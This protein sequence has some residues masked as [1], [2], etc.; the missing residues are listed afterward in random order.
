VAPGRPPFVRSAQY[1]AAIIHAALAA[2]GHSPDLVQIVTGEKEIL[3][4]RRKRGILST[5]IPTHIYTL[6]HDPP[7]SSSLPGFGDAGAALVNSGVD[8]LTFI[9]SPA[10]GKL[11]MRAAADTLT[12]VVLELGGKDAAIICE[13]CDYSQA[14]WQRRWGR[15]FC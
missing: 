2:V 4:K 13:D 12:P 8:K 6:L 11:V 5:Y 3:Q 9:G 10:V 14:R 1:Y 15:E 7:P